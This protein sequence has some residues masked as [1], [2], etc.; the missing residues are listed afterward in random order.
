MKLGYG[1]TAKSNKKGS[2]TKQMNLVEGGGG[3]GD[4]QVKVIMGKGG[5]YLHNATRRRGRGGEM[6]NS[7]DLVA[8]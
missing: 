7:I 6:D 2:R 4:G 5:G 8:E 1:P 3:G